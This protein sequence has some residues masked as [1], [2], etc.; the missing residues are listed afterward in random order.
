MCCICGKDLTQ[1]DYTTDESALKRANIAMA[2]DTT[3]VRVSKR[4]RSLFLSAVILT[5]QV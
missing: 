3:G 2:H 1:L 4:V 5:E